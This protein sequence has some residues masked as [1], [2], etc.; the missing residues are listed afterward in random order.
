MCLRRWIAF[1]GLLV[2]LLFS[3]TSAAVTLTLI[4]PSG[5]T[6]ESSRLYHDLLQEFKKAEPNIHVEFTPLIRWD[7]VVDAVRQL[8]VQRKATVF[9]AEVSET[10][11][12]EELG[13]IEPFENVLNKLGGADAFVASITPEFLGNSYCK[14]R[15]L[16]GPPF[17]RSMPVAFY[18][19]DRLK[20]VGLTEDQLP[21]TWDEL[22]TML[23]KLQARYRQAPFC[24]GGDWYDYLFEATVL[25][26]GGALMDFEQ[27]K[28]VLNSAK[29]IEALSFW[30]R[31]KDKGLLIRMNNWKST[32][33]AFA[34]GY[35]MVAYY[36]SG[37]METVRSRAKF[38]WAADMLPRNKQYGVAMGGGNLYFSA[39][40]NVE[41]QRAAL[42]L[43]KFL[44]K[45]LV[46]A[47]IS[48]AT[49]FFPVV[50]AAIAE[51]EFKEHYFNDPSFSRVQRQLKY[52]KP[53]IMAA[54]N[55]KMRAILKS[56]ID[57]SLNEGVAPEI[58]LR[59]AQ[60]E[61]RQLANY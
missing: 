11:E 47:R 36:S 7:D 43:A 30:K 16:C 61:I 12:L 24:F 23:V 32:V 13:L 53:K 35:C 59:Q 18:N 60:Q 55:L 37:G 56:A 5:A 15:K 3:R 21:T 29:A 4:I 38:S 51:P 31:L 25:Q 26:S 22:E 46:Q 45:P 28:I 42:Q 58:A 17:I 27:N 48:V 44:Y 41:E 34:A 39:G 49:G 19:L 52:A 57:K 9:V 20:E 40:M 33:N 1:I 50:S 54:N 14:T 6:S 8:Q 10:L 2:G